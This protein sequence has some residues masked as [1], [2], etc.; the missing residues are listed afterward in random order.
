MAAKKNKSGKKKAEQQSTQSPDTNGTGCASRLSLGPGTRVNLTARSAALSLPSHRE[1]PMMEVDTPPAHESEMQ[2]ENVP[3]GSQSPEVEAVADVRVRAEQLKEE[4]NIAFR[5]KTYGTAINLYS[6]AIDL[7]PA[8]PTYLTNRAASY[9]AL[10][11]FKPALADCQQAASLQSANPSVKT[12]IRL[13]RCQLAVGSPGPALSVLREVLALEPSNVSAK[14]LQAKVLELEAHLRNFDGA[15]SRKDWGMARL[16]LDRCVQSIEGEAGD[17]PSEWRCWR[18]ELELARGSW[19]AAASAANEALRLDSSSA[20]VLALRGLVLFLTA[21]LP[22][23]LQHAM[24]ALRLDPD[25]DRAKKLRQRVKAVEKLK[26]E[27]N[28]CFKTGQWQPAI[29]KYTEALEV[30]G[31]SE[32]EGKG[33]QMRATLLSNRATSLLK[34]ERH[35]DALTDITASL[36]LYPTSFKALRTR[37]RINE[38]LEQYDAAVA[39]FKAAIEQAGNEGSSADETALRTELRKAEAALKRSKT[40]DYYKIL[41]VARDCTELDIKKA[42]RRESLKHHPDKGGDEE[43]FKLVV[44]AHTVLSDPRRRERYDMGAD[45]DGSVD[46]G[47]GMNGMHGFG[48]MNPEDLSNIFMQFGG[49]GGGGF[50]GGRSSFGG[51]GGGFGFQSSR[52]SQSF[53]F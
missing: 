45:E 23:A 35:A 13:A 21:K 1:V 40:K 22:G 39:D 24:S 18:I 48:G 2:A 7:Q 42:Y 17:T 30:V 20:D 44:E 26:E 29:D 8:E 5:E 38:H 4:G 11:R 53:H 46:S 27:G 36:E 33:G 32:E 47:G 28:S 52:P 25:N 15:R 41:G 14:Q 34:L 9:M 10:R 31:D 50:G 16:A 37:A 19:D 51:H 6:Q 49:G 12:L 43:K 3:S